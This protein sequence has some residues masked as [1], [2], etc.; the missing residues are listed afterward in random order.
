[1]GNKIY[2]KGKSYGEG[3]AAAETKP[4]TAAENEVITGDGKDWLKGSG[5][6]IKDSKILLNDLFIEGKEDPKLKSI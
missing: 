6:D 1:M 5:I 3:G 4:I 2:Y